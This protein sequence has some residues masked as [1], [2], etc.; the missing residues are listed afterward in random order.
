MA[1]TI[2]GTMT[3]DELV[4]WAREEVAH[5]MNDGW[6]WYSVTRKA[7]PWQHACMMAMANGEELPTPNRRIAAVRTLELLSQA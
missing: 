6:K 2:Y 5:A 4:D 3:D 1:T 7:T